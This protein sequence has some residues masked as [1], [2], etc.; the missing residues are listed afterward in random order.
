MRWTSPDASADLHNEN[1]DTK[2]KQITVT[3][4]NNISIG[5]TTAR[6]DFFWTATRE[7]LVDAVPAS[8]RIKNLHDLFQ[9][10]FLTV[11]NAE[12]MNTITIVTICF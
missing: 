8:F 2:T 4:T 3:L 6:I 10:A 7:I 9:R 5:I 12:L 11:D 1:S